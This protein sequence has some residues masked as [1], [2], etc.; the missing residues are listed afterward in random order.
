MHSDE[1]IQV[2]LAEDDPDDRELVA[3]ALDE[4]RWRTELH[5][6]EDGED[7]MDYL[8]RRKTYASD[9]DSPR[10]DLIL[11]DLNMPRKNGR[12]AVRE[13]KADAN[14]RQ[15]PVVVLTTSKSDEDIFFCYDAGVNSY[16][17]KPETF[18]VF[19]DVVKQLHHY[20]LGLGELPGR[21]S[22]D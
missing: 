18:G 6:V 12:E 7:L 8:H 17:T 19:L 9:T 14:L 13:I 3:Q 22:R 15:I 5:I 10:P 2:L 21:E 20:W 16:V 1:P 11:L 4:S